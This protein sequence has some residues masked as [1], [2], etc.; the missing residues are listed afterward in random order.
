MTCYLESLILSGILA[1]NPQSLDHNY[2]S[3]FLRFSEIFIFDSHLCTYVISKDITFFRLNITDY[4]KQMYF[5]TTA[6]M[7]FHITASSF[8]FMLSSSSLFHFILPLSFFPVW[9]VRY[10]M[11]FT[12]SSSLLISSSY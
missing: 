10:P 7:K 8:S 2:N 1:G 9:I 6:P 5:S 12:L 11:R 3:Y 4:G